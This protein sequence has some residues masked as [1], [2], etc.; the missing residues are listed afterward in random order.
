VITYGLYDLEPGDVI[1]I[2]I[3]PRGIDDEFAVAEVDYSW[4]RDETTL[5]I[6]EKTGDVDEVLF[7]LSDTVKRLETADANRQGV[8]DKLMRTESGVLLAA[9]ASEFSGGVVGDSV[10]TSVVTNTGLNI[11]RDAFITGTN[12]TLD[13]VK[14]GSSNDNLSRGNTDIQST[15]LATGSLSNTDVSVSDTVTFDFDVSQDTIKTL[16]SA[17]Y[18]V[19]D[20]DAMDIAHNV[21]HN[22]NVT[23]DNL[24]TLA[25]VAREAG[26]EFDNEEFYKAAWDVDDETAEVELSDPADV[27][28]GDEFENG[29]RLLE[30]VS[31]RKGGGAQWVTVKDLC[32]NTAEWQGAD[33]QDLEQVN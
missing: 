32:G 26:A 23:V 21:E 6:V 28:V 3:E 7:Q 4:V 25:D 20:T 8:S 16:C 30:V 33:L 24:E 14:L 1:N 11:V 10:E 9:T 19:G 5:T 18:T 12:P 31:T 22:R 29:R 17:A 15:E 2:E 13:T 27:Q